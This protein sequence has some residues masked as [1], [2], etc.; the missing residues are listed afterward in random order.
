MGAQRLVA[1]REILLCVTIEVAE[2]GRQAVAAV[3]Q[4]REAEPPQRILQP[5]GQRHETLA[6]EHDMGVFPARE[7]EPEVIEPVIERRAGDAD[8]ATAHVGE[9][10]QPEPS[11][12]V[13][14]PEDDSLLGA[15]QRPPGADAPFQGAPDAGPELG[16]TAADLIENGDRP[17]AGGAFQQRHHLAIPNRGKRISPAADARRLLL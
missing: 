6:A 7:S 13:L 12:R 9:I 1:T 11:R 5:L 3:L 4:G 14:L 8:A 10:G 2:S 15:M 16:M 17:Q